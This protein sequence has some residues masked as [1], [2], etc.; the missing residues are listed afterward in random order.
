MIRTASESDADDIREISKHLG[1]AE[2]SPE[3]SFLNLQAILSSPNDQIYVAECNGSVVGWLHLFYAKRLASEGFHEI[4]GL[5]VSPRYRG[6]GIGRAL[7]EYALDKNDGEIRV[8]CN[9][10]RSE[11]HRFYEA[12]GFRCSKAQHVFHIRAQ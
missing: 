8:R 1:Y 4:G 11:S 6:Q 5:V 2:L 7:V 10:Q 12:I 3:Q 9:A